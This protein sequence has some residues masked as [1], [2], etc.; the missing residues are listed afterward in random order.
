MKNIEVINKFV[1][2]YLEVKGNKNLR[3]EGAKLFNYETC[4]AEW[5]LG[6][7]FINK[8][9]YSSSTSIIQNQLVSVANEV[10]GH[11]SVKVINA[12]VPR[13]SKRLVI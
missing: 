3:I 5:H 2:G 9:K 7:I 1:E 12:Y 4:I 10:I 13:G 8:T 6:E 11:H